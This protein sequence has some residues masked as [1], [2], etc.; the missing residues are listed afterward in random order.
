MLRDAGAVLIQRC[1]P[2]QAGGTAGL[3][4]RPRATRD[5]RRVR[6][7]VRRP[8]IGDPAGCI[9]FGIGTETSGSILSPSSR[10]G[11]A[12]LRP[13][14]GRVSRGV[15]ALCGRRDRFGA[16]CRYAE[17]TA[18]VMQAIAK[19]TA[20]CWR[21]SPMC[22]STGTRNS[23]SRPRGRHHPG[24]VRQITNATAKPA[25]TRCWLACSSLGVTT[26]IP[27]KVR[28]SPPTPAALA[29]SRPRDG[30]SRAAA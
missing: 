13:T 21:A 12:G 25:P 10:C 8:V 30:H 9:A 19:P 17:D 24:I 14:S 3:A 28:S 23:T 11:L 16:I 27:V 6:G 18:I 7:I 26:F 29:W 4:G 1:P 22:R 2:G 15:M 20:F 5:P